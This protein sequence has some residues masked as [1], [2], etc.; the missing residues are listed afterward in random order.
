VGKAP[1]WLPG[2]GLWSA[3]GV[4]LTSTAGPYSRA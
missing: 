1:T 3:S 4:R 2:D